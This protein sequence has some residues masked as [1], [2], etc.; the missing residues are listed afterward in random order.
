MLMSQNCLVLNGI[1]PVADFNDGEVFSDIVNV[2]NW[3]HASWVIYKGIGATGVGKI[4]FEPCSTNA[5]AA[6]GSYV[7]GKVRALTNVTAGN[8]YGAVEDVLTTGYT[9]TAGTNQ[10]YIAELNTDELAESGYKWVRL[11]MQ[12]PTNDPVTGA[13]LCI[14]SEPRYAGASFSNAMA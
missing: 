9:L 14:L 10:L 11:M 12:E 1:P 5:A 8:T 2:A 7:P 3:G 4:F 6:T 13:I